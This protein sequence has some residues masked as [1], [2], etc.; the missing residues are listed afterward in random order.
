MQ[1]YVDDFNLVSFSGDFAAM[2]CIKT[3]I[4]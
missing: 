1:I 2:I 4:F 3:N